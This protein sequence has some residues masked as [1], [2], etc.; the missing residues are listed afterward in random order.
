MNGRNL[1][2]PLADDVNIQELA[3]KY[4]LCGRDIRNAV[5]DACV[6]ACRRGKISVDQECLE[7]GARARVESNIAISKA[8]DHTNAADANSAKA[9]IA[10]AMEEKLKSGEHKT[11]GIDQMDT[12]K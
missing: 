1:S 2:I 6:E 10:K 5:V 7:F 9:V 12:E 3:E 4:A 8:D 11:I